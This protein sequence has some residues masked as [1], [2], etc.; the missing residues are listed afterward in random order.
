MRRSSRSRTSWRTFSIRSIRRRGGVQSLA[1]LGI[2]ANADGSYDTNTTTLSNALTSSLASVGNL[3][4]G[5][6][7]IATQLNNL[8]MA[9][10]KPGGLLATINQGL[11]TSLT[12]VA[13]QQ[14]A[15][16]ARAGDLFGHADR[17]IQRDGHGRG[18]AQGDSDLP[19]G[20]I[21]SEPAPASTSSTNSSLSSG[22]LST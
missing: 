11:Q 9:I 12:N 8:I 2:T 20:R 17:R 7:G 16:N 21:Q 1:D 15:L 10:R 19:E 13:Q 4:G 6:N 5:T 14:T 18:V 3:L 22:N